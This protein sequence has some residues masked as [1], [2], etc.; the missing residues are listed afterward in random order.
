MGLDEHKA[1][2]ELAMVQNKKKEEAAAREAEQRR[3]LAAQAAAYAEIA[4]EEGK[5]LDPAQA[6]ALAEAR[7]SSRSRSRENKGFP[8]SRTPGDL[9]LLGFANAAS[10]LMT[11]RRAASDKN[12]SHEG[13]DGIKAELMRERGLVSSK[14]KVAS[15]E[16]NSSK[17]KNKGDRSRSRD[18]KRNGRTKTRSRSRGKDR[19]KR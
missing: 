12:P 9:G 19:D 2:K 10:I 15:K 16:K 1:A 5:E 18:R 6:R 17:E 11:K 13:L 4:L 14:E 8:S 3:I 7:K